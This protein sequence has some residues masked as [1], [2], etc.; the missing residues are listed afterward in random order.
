VAISGQFGLATDPL[1]FFIDGNYQVK[2]VGTVVTGTL[3]SGTVKP[4]MTLQL[5]PTK[6]GGFS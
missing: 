4:G 3:L 5:G 1:E 6:L 2:G